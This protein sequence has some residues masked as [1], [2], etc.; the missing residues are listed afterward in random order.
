METPDTREILR[1]F[2]TFAVVGLSPKPH[3]DSH[4]VAQFLQEH[5]YRIIPVRPG[6]ESILGEKCYATLME[7]PG[8]VEVV[9]LFR[10]SEAVAPFVDEA[11]A[12]QAKVVW[13][14]L[15]VIHEEAAEKARRAGLLVV[16]DHC[17][18]IEYRKH[19]G[20]SPRPT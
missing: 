1:K 7:I 19:F 11:I 20:S 9:D 14:Q 18:V 12:I 15:G 3:R 17:P 10:R 13:M 8:R 4:R 2:R 5:G 16:M 6:A